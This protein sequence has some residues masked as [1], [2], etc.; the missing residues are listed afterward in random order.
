MCL[1]YHKELILPDSVT[2]IEVTP[3]LAEI[4]KDN[5]TLIRGSLDSFAEG[6]ASANGLPFRP[7]DFVF[8]E[9]VFE[10]ARESTT[11]ILLFH[12]N[13][14]VQIKEDIRSPGTSASNTLG[15]SFYYS[16]PKDF[17]LTKTAEEIAGMFRS[18]LHDA[19]LQ[20]GRLAAFLQKA[21]THSLYQGKN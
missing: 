17:Y 4:L 14:S 18:V 16:L 6:F 9:Y 2:H 8:A 12:R 7:A 21:N 1:L 3:R 13:G 10:P 19:I 11:M 15:G 5:H 20:D